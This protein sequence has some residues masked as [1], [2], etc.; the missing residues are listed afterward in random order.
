M[1]IIV[2][3]F[4]I[5]VY[6]LDISPIMMIADP[7][8]ALRLLTPVFTACKAI[9]DTWKLTKSFGREFFK[10]ECMLDAQFV[11]LMQIGTRRLDQL[12]EPID[13][14]DESDPTTRVIHGLLLNVQTI[15]NQCGELIFE[16]KSMYLPHEQTK[17][18]QLLSAD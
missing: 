5:P 10:A 6:S 4:S 8:S 7:L 18:Q 16:Y 9:F 15:F 17:L 3:D 11:R 2:L 12:A 13:P 14:N 1:R